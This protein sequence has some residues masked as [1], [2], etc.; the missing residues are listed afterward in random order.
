[1]KQK[2]LKL[3]NDKLNTNELRI[4]CSPKSISHSRKWE[5]N[6]IIEK[7]QDLSLKDQL[8]KIQFE[9]EAYTN[10]KKNLNKA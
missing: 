3:Q 4:D 5:H 1:M 8:D 10:Q 9:L 7:R 2:L 6:I